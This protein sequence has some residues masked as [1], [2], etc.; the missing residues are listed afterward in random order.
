M[1]GSY[2]RSAFMKY[3]APLIVGLTMSTMDVKADG[4]TSHKAIPDIDGD[5]IGEVLTSVNGVRD[6]ADFRRASKMYL[7]TSGGKDTVLGDFDHEIVDFRY[8]EGSSGS[9]ILVKTYG[10]TGHRKRC[11]F[12]EKTDKGFKQPVRVRTKFFRKS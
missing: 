3:A 9:G 6:T 4:Y 11:Y 1:K 10:D 2:L 8:T 7:V 5:G 12:M